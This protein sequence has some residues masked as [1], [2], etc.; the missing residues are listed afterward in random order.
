MNTTAANVGGKPRRPFYRN[1]SVQILVAMVLG[2]LLGYLWPSVGEALKPLSTIFIRLVTMLV[3]LIIF[4]TVVHGIASVRE[5]RS[6]GRVALKAIILFEIITT[7]ALIIGIIMVNLL[8]PG[9]GMHIDPA[10]LTDQNVETYAAAAKHLTVA[11][12]FLD[13]IP[14][15]AVGAFAQG[16]ILQVLLFSLLFAFGLSA[17]GERVA[18]PILVFVESFSQVLFRMIGYVMVIAPIGAFAAIAFTVGKFGV[19]SLLPLGKLLIEFY[20]CCAVFVF[21][22]FWPIAR[23]AK[24]SLFKLIR[25]IWAELLIVFGTSSTE[26]VFPQLVVKLRA[27]G[28]E[29]SVVGLVMP[30]SYAFNH[31]GTCLYFATASVFLAQAVGIH[32]S[33]G[34]Q[35]GLLAIMLITSKGGGGVTGSS[36]VILTMTIGASGLIPIGAVGIILGVHLLLSS[37][38]VPIT[39]LGNALSTI[40]IAKWEN[41]L[42][43]AVLDS[44]L[45]RG[46]GFQYASALND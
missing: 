36:F 22:V 5:A 45:K 40:V 17:V 41:A 29:E 28:C 24:L 32:L 38:F 14:K 3:G 20:T 21:V 37:V 39:V 1:L 2:A 12:F 10:T 13:M 46:S 9:A 4:C 44:E 6:A 19:A 26:S 30:T 33:I 27:L 34:Q 15:T 18:S 31:S 16:E 23:M 42:D 25:Y 35:L 8:T 7:L 43:S 11:G